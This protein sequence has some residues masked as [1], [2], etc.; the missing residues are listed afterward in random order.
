[1]NKS[2]SEVSQQIQI[3]AMFQQC[4]LMRN[5][6][7]ELPNRDGTPVRYGLGNVSKEHNKDVKSSDLIGITK[8][9]I[10]PEM[11][12]KTVG[13]FTA[14][15]CKKEDWN[16]DKKFDKREIAQQNFIDWV[17]AC[18]GFSGFANSVESIKNIIRW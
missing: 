10:T 2:E 14:I 12:G 6:S 5:N 13:V 7:G 4:N 17:K 8:V 1:M 3:R 11:V 16:P 15:E 18:G 9:L